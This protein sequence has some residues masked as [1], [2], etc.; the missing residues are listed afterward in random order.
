MAMPDDERRLGAGFHWDAVTGTMRVGQRAVTISTPAD[1]DAMLAAYL[2]LVAEARAK[3]PIGFGGLRDDDIDALARILDLDDVDLDRRLTRLL[4]VSPGTA[5]RIRVRLRAR[6]HR[7]AIA[8]VAV[9]LGTAAWTG[10]PAAASPPPAPAASPAAETPARAD[11]V[12]PAPTPTAHNRPAMLVESN[13]GPP[14]T[15]AVRDAP[16]PPPAAG[17]GVSGTAESGTDIGS[18]EHIERLDDGSLAVI[19]ESVETPASADGTDI[20]SAE[21]IERVPPPSP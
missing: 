15:L 9:G 18:A 8:G 20:G 1:N 17:N 19:D 6:A 5:R 21:T 4:S 14:A 7:L 3:R 10:L 16:D 2:G 11:S 12:A 13:P